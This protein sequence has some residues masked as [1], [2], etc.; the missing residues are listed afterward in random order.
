M[1]AAP[2]LHSVENPT[3]RFESGAETIDHG[4]AAT[5]PAPPSGGGTD[6]KRPR[7]SKPRADKPLPTD[8]LKFDNQVAVLRYVA[9]T[10]GTS[11]R[12]STADA[13]SAAVDLRGG[14]GGLNSRFFQSAGWFEAVNRGEYTASA[15]TIA[16]NQHITI[17]PGA[18]YDAAAQ[19]RDEVTSSWFWETLH[20]LIESGQPISTRVALLELAR[21][22]GATDHS[23]QLDT[24]IDWLAWVGLVIRDGDQIKLQPTAVTTAQAE[25]DAAT[26]AVGLVDDHGA[27]ADITET[28]TASSQNSGAAANGHRDA[29]DAIVSFNLSVRLTAADMENLD[30]QKREFILALAEKLRG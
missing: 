30:E 23:A 22:S 6:E 19:M 28:D 2:R 4:G 15:G 16:W 5:P 8:R 26:D 29:D 3:A 24:I 17:D 18:Q 10:S 7:A 25:T 11:R 21:A 13:M 14:T 20:P 12:G 27:E 9:Q 1:N